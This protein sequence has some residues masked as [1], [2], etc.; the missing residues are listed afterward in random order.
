M[1]TD[2]IA[3]VNLKPA[4]GAEAIDEMVDAGVATWRTVMR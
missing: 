3:A 1:L 2:A 4:D